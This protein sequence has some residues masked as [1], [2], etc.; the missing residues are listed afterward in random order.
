MDCRSINL[1]Q[2]LLPADNQ[3]ADALWKEA[4]STMRRKIV[5]LDDDPTGVQT[6]HGVNVYTDWSEESLTS[7]FGEE[8][9]CFFVLTNS[10]S[11][12]ATQTR[13]V[14]MEIGESL[15]RVAQKTQKDFIL[16]SRS[17]STLRGHYPLETEVLKSSIESHSSKRFDGEILLPFF[18]EGGRYTIDNCHYVR[19]KDMLV[20]AGQTEFARDLAFSYQNSDLGAYVEEK[21]GGKYPRESC[22]FI[23]LEDL[24]QLKVDRIAEQLSHVDG[25][26]KVIV[27][28][29]DYADVKVFLT[30]YCKALMQ[31]KEFLFRTAAAVPKV[32]AG[33]DE[34]PYLSREDILLDDNPNGGIILVGSHVNLSTQQLESLKESQIPMEFIEFNQH[35]VAVDGGLEEEAR[36]T[37]SLAQDAIRSGKNAVVYTRRQRYDPPTDDQAE[38]LR[39]STR[40][41]QSLSTVAGELEIRPRFVI[42]KGGITSSDIGTKALRIKKAS[43][44]GQVAPGVSVWIT[45]EESLFPHLPYIIFPGNVG[46]RDTLR[47]VVE[48]LSS[49]SLS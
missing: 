29:A 17:D 34:Q 28:A 12:S 22:V 31:G 11:F 8:N 20:P 18:A 33:I 19:Q 41:S 46:E 49:P 40:I 7:G 6:M 39:I 13:Q 26:R 38:Q 42:A 9:D 1:L 35:L 4:R 15:C 48:K 24:R 21:T 14:H 10:R 47:Q 5:V 3:K 43:I 27:N 37:R 30:A 23:S 2:S 45:G 32:L 44:P 16:V 25:F 36:R